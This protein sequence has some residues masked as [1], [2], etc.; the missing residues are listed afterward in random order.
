MLSLASEDALFLIILIFTTLGSEKAS[1]LCFS[2]CALRTAWQLVPYIT[3]SQPDT[4]ICAPHTRIWYT[5]THT[6]SHAEMQICYPKWE[7]T[8]R[9]EENIN[10][11]TTSPRYALFCPVWAFHSNYLMISLRETHPFLCERCA[12]FLDKRPPLTWH[13]NIYIYIQ[14]ISVDIKTFT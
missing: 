1:F 2:V 12:S 14:Y 3:T 13:H 5:C 8:N 6:R 9:V 7:Y 4:H 11:Q 10:I